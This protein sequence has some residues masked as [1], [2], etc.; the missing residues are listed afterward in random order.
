MILC[1]TATHQ[2]FLQ[3]VSQSASTL[4]TITAHVRLNRF[5]KRR[6]EGREKEAEGAYALYLYED[7]KVAE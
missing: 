7:K 4:E 6:K 3:I 5:S 2:N 1:S